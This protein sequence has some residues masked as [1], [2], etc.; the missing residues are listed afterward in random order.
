M[1]AVTPP[2]IA[3]L[4]A[5]LV[6]AQLHAPGSHGEWSA[7]DV[8]AHMRSCADVWGNCIA[9]IIAEDMP[10]IRAINP[11]TWIKSTDYF[12]QEFQPSLQA[13]AAQRTDLLAVLEPLGPEDWSRAA[14]V[15]GAG[16]PLVRTVLSYAQWLARHE[17]PHVKQI[18]RIVK[19]MGM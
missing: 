1:L 2:R 12:E 9:M 14:T 5:G 15:T 3:A 17:R 19:T 11:R 13:F 8:L 18:E 4:T 16:K 10:T 7:N 6:P